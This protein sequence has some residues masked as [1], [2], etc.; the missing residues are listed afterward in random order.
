MKNQKKQET[1]TKDTFMKPL[2]KKENQ[3]MQ[4]FEGYLCDGSVNSRPPPKLRAA[5]LPPQAV[6]PKPE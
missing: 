1:T 2:N 4:L 5:I 6:P 3:L